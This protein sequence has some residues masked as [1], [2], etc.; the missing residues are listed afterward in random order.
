[1]KGIILAGVDNFFIGLL[2]LIGMMISYHVR[3]GLAIWTLPLLLMA[4]I[5][6]IR[7]GL[8]LLALNMHYCDNGYITPFLTQFWIRMASFSPLDDIMHP[9]LTGYHNCT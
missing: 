3:P 9:Y 1:M 2:V 8:W 7:I 4:L 5:A 6:A